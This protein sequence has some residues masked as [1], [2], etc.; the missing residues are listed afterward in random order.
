MVLRIN[1]ANSGT[2]GGSAIYLFLNG[3]AH[4]IGNYSAIT[5][6]AYNSDFTLYTGGSSN[7]LFCMGGAEKARID[8][9]GKLLIGYT[10]S[11]NS[12]KLQVN[13]S[14]YINNS[15]S[16]VPS[17][18]QVTNAASITAGSYGGGYV[19][20]DGTYYLGM[21]S[22]SGELWLGQGTSAGLTGKVN[23]GANDLKFFGAAQGNFQVNASNGYAA[24]SAVSSGTNNSYI[25]F[26]NGSGECNRIASDNTGS[27]AFYTGSSATLSFS[28]DGAMNAQNYGDQ[29]TI[30]N[31]SDATTRQ[32][33]LHFQSNVRLLYFCL[34]SDNSF[35]LWDQQVSANRWITDTSGNFTAAGNVTAYSDSRLK[36]DVQRITSALDTVM[37]LRGVSFK[38]NRDKSPGIGFIAQ[39]VE[40][41]L[42]ELVL[43]SGTVK[44]VAYGNVSAVLVEAIRELKSEMDDLRSQLG[45]LK[46]R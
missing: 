4:A 45:A 42:P 44:S 36:H 12:A 31:G 26:S 32:K 21:Y 17:N 29:F 2:A 25:F 27:L 22:I 37:A 46:A 6:S 24:F 5:G 23:V 39:E 15:T 16:F 9:N 38:W 19:M 34:N 43:S 3:G 33:R 35:A 40:E 10:T 41:V 28:I 14:Q 7:L 18:T 13:G 11:Q 30:G 8:T 1:G 20:V